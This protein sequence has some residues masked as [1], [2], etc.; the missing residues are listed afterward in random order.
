MRRK[1][2]FTR[3][4]G[5]ELHGT[6][7][8]KD[9]LAL[10]ELSRAEL[11][12][13]SVSAETSQSYYRYAE[14]VRRVTG[15]VS[16]IHFFAFLGLERR[17]PP[18]TGHS[19]ADENTRRAPITMRGF[20]CACLHMSL[21]ENTPWTSDQSNDVDVGLNGYEGESEVRRP[22][23]MLTTEQVKQVIDLA[24]EMDK[25]Q[26][27]CGLIL[28]AGACCRP[29]DIP[30]LTKGDVSHDYQY[31][32][33]E[34]KGPIHKKKRN[35]WVEPKFV[36]WESACEVLELRLSLMAEDPPD[37]KLFPLFSTATASALVRQCA[38]MYAWD[39]S[40]LYDGAH[41]FR[42]AS[43]AEAFDSALQAA[44]ERG[45]WAGSDGPIRYAV[46]G[47]TGW[48]Q[49]MTTRENVAV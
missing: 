33:C 20:K 13:K 18:P 32:H 23:G 3:Q 40:I 36:A 5:S 7:A 17:K 24:F 16:S 10:A 44:R 29:R 48:S 9:M 49:A 47:R 21:M 38:E 28:I 35:G 25:C 6:M 4:P 22:R 8:D 27:A 42:H 39:R 14:E 31:I 34:M 37:E 46:R 30:Q 26:T 12:T 45:G 19:R 15:G 43:A 11:I 2:V 1:T 41:C